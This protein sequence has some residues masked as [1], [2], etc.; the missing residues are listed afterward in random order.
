MKREPPPP[1]PP[2]PPPPSSGG[3]RARDPAA[4]GSASEDEAGDEPRGAG[5][6]AE[7]AVVRGLTLV[8]GLLGPAEQVGCLGGGGGTRRAADGGPARGGLTRR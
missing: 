8:R 4:W 7:E 3:G 6:E 5:P 1:P 2:G